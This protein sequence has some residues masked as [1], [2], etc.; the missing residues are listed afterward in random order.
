MMSSSL[1]FWILAAL[2][3]VE[4]AAQGLE[5][6]GVAEKTLSNRMKVLLVERSGSGAVHARLFAQGGR[7]QTGGLPPAAADLL[8]RT[9]FARYVPPELD[10]RMEG[11]LAQE[12]G[13][14]EAVRLE[15]LRSARLP[16]AEA[17]GETQH[18][19][20]IHQQAQAAILEKLAPLEAWDA[21][22]ALGVTG[23]E[24]EVSADYLCH[25]ADM[26]AA[27][28][29]TWCRTE[30]SR[31]RNLPLARFPLER[32]RMT[33]EIEAGGAPTSPSLSI[34]LATALAGQSYAQV[35]D[36]RRSG[37]EALA[38]EDLKDYAA[39]A[40]RPSSLT[41]VLVGDLKAAEAF[42]FLEE[43]FGRLGSAAEKGRAASAES[44]RPYRGE[45]SQ[46]MLQAPGGR[47]LVVRTTGETKLYMAWEVP[48]ATHPDG[49][50]LR[51]LVQVLGGSPGSRLNPFLPGG[52]GL[53]RSLSVTLG[54]PGGRDTN[55][56]LIQGEPAEGRSLAE[57]EHA[58]QGEI[59]KLQ[60]DPPPDAEF[61]RVQI[62]LEAAQ[63]GAQEDARDLAKLQGESHCE[64]G[65]WKLSFMALESGR[66]LRPALIQIAARTY[67][68]PARSTV[69]QLGPD[70]L[71]QPK[72]RLEGRMLQV[73]TALVRR[74]MGE[75][76]HAEEVI[77]EA[78][79]QMRMLSTAER[80][81]A[82]K[83]LEEQVRP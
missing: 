28:F 46:G 14:F 22:D 82:V 74:K 63:I 76:A 42:P 43:T 27:A 10:R 57:L 29:F 1:L 60:R 47:R 65:D 54:V 44:P 48:P 25:G 2:L 71:L 52:R 53:A 66:D 6:P 21:L 62:Q 15:R 26:P 17:G 18:L 45:D 36:F 41:L 24:T 35:A 67:L 5:L 79:R 72:D 78:L 16:G 56:L 11:L 34:L 40:L 55:L 20:A 19:K 8:A 61:R 31:L 81:Q 80:E 3:G 38:W 69:A 73:L 4:G 59:L 50:A 51:A 39:R 30:A 58:I 75:A 37:V 9:L 70:P 7:A 83:L 32:E 77:R 68:T 13:A 33:L 23:R 12:G 49:A 64:G